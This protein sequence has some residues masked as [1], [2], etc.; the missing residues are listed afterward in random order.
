MPIERINS[1]ARCCPNCG[2][3]E[4]HYASCDITCKMQQKGFRLICRG[5]GWK[6]FRLQLVKKPG[7]DAPLLP[8]LSAA[9]A[10]QTKKSYKPK[11]PGT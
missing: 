7:A 8:E 5:C 1:G 11:N 3:D 2:G 6:G 4:F 9:M 10:E